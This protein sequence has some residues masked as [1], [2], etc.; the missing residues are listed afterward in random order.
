MPEDLPNL[1]QLYQLGAFSNGT[2][3]F[4]DADGKKATGTILPDGHVM[5]LDK[6]FA[7]LS[8]AAGVAITT[9]TGRTT[10]GRSY[11]SVNGWKFW[12]Y[13]LP[14]DHILTLDELRRKFA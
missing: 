13:K 6:E 4:A 12:K 9:L 2:T 7:S 11:A 3:I 8:V 14:D 1:E 10:F 5:T